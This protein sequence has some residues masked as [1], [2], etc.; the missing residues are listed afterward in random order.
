MVKLPMVLYYNK[1]KAAAKKHVVRR[2][3]KPTFPPTTSQTLFDYVG[4]YNQWNVHFTDKPHI[5]MDWSKPQ[6]PANSADQTSNQAN[7]QQDQ[8]T[9]QAAPAADQTS[10]QAAPVQ[11]NYAAPAASAP[12][13]SA[14]A[15]SDYPAAQNAYQ[16]QTASPEQ[17]T[18]Y[19][20]QQPASAVADSTATQ[21]KDDTTTIKLPNSALEQGRNSPHNFIK[22]ST[23]N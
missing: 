22:H 18:G 20:N 9:A 13:A 5:T 10:Y 4:G 21:A 19:Q 7:T 2:A 23:N 14:P 17:N 16:P 8:Q 3:A 11:N 1:H 12:A 6:P 15:A